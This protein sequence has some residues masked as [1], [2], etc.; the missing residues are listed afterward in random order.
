MA[1]EKKHPSRDANEG[2]RLASTPS[3]APSE[4]ERRAPAFT[5]A[6]PRSRLE[7]ATVH[8]SDFVI[9]VAP[10]LFLHSVARES[11]PLPPPFRRGGWRR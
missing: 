6:A 3:R 8:W 9:R 10:V 2:P 7:S 1:N 4:R 11:R 5:F